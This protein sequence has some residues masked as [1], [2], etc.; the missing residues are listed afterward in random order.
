MK[1]NCFANEECVKLSHLLSDSLGGLSAAQT[2]P[3]K[4]TFLPP[5]S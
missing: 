1:P 5:K 3:R 4:G 2:G